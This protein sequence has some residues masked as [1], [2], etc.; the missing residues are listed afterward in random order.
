MG[1]WDERGVVI[2]KKCHHLVFKDQQQMV[3]RVRIEGNRKNIKKGRL[4]ADPD[5]KSVT[6]H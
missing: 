2:L 5:L 1:G 3:V 6:G 4:Q